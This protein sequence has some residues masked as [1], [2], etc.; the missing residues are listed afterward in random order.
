MNLIH[1][2]LSRISSRDACV[3]VIGLGYVGLPLLLEINKSGFH[4]LGL[5]SDQSRIDLLKKGITPI[6]TIRADQVSEAL[7]RQ[8]LKFSSSYPDT[9]NCQVY[10]ICLPTPLGLHRE[11]DLSYIKSAI[12]NLLP[13]FKEGDLICLESTSFPGTTELLIVE[14]LLD[15]GFKPGE[16]IFIVYSPEREDP[17]NKTYTTKTIPKVLGAYS[18]NC[19]KIG[20]LFYSSFI[21]NLVRVS[22]CK[23]AEMTKL[24]ENI[25][26]SVNIGLVNEMK[27]LASRMDIDIY[28]VIAAA[29]TKPFGFVPYYPGPGLGGHCIPI[30]PFYLTWKAREYGLHTRFIELAGEINSSM[31]DYVVE[32]IIYALNDRSVCISNSKLLV[33]GMSY[34]KGIDDIRESPSI[35]ISNLLFALGASLSFSDPFVDINA[36]SSQPFAKSITKVEPTAEIIST[37]DAVLILTDHDEFDYPAIR[38]NSDLIIDTRGRYLNGDG[39]V[40]A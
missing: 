19:H 38:A 22:D 37:F 6:R 31:P 27:I 29:S 28:E 32:K 10:V 20:S 13:L 9:A 12:D 16:D 7:D 39:I 11:P 30:D 33:L 18:D 23:T 35:V 3:C 17:G 21:D 26:R 25:H 1:S 24:L 40:R 15:Y 36:L 34:K 5:D 2:Y 8:T 4:C 14:P